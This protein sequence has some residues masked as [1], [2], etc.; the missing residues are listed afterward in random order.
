MITFISWLMVLGG[1]YGVVTGL[2]LLLVA[3]PWVLWTCVFGVKTAEDWADEFDR[4]KYW[5]A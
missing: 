4:R 3:V 2:L 5:K 1:A